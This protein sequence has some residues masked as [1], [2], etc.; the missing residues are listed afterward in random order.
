MQRRKPHT[1]IYAT[2]TLAFF[3]QLLTPSPFIHSSPPHTLCFSLS[4]STLFHC[5]LVV[6][7]ARIKM[8]GWTRGK[9]IGKG[10]FGTVH[11]A[12][13]RATGRA[14]A[15]KSVH[16][17]G[18]AP[19]AAMACLE[20][21][22]RILRRLSSP[23]I[24]AYLGDDA[25]AS[26]RNLHMELVSGGSAAARGA[27]GLGERA[28]RCVLR[29]VAAAL[30]YLHD[31]AG[32]VH[33]DVKGRNVLVGGDGAEYGSSKLADFGAARL[34]SEPAPRGPRGTPAWMAPEVARGGAST[35]A[36][37]VWS[38]GCTAVELLT[39]K[40]PWSEMGGALEVGELLLHIGYGVKRPELPACL[41]DSCSDFLD[42]CLRRDAGE[43]WSCEQLLRHPFLSADPH[44]AGEPS[45]SP[46]PRAV[47]DWAA[48]DSDSDASSDCHPAADIEDEV[49]MA[50]AKGRIAELAS[51]RPRPDWVR[52]LEEGPTWAPDTWAPP[53]SLEMSTDA[54]LLPLVP[55]PS[56]AATVA[57]AGNGGAGGPVVSRDGVLVTGGSDG[58][59][60]RVRGRCWCD[61]RRGYHKCG[62]GFDRPPCWPPL[63]V[64]SVL[65]SCILSHLIQSM[66]LFQQADGELIL[67]FA[68]VSGS[69]FFYSAVS[70]SCFFGGFD[71]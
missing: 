48:S 11:L 45:P 7:S 29:R 52:E 42:K 19:A 2:L 4:S 34:V 63:A 60:C 70:G 33:G 8:E 51:D 27:A 44:D 9:C 12:V 53:P 62:S 57:G 1:Y 5:P 41:S 36:S 18:A 49:I 59:S 66:I 30:H 43:R 21:E 38:L 10:A 31:V 17:K 13:H 35:P 24:V 71:F 68:T 15:V 40:R 54:V 69:V 56:D 20:T 28:A 47:L 32:V 16:A 58:G 14:F 25:T 67:F 61:D 65:V 39:G 23:Y 55:S 46:S 26:T 3:L 50:S 22:I 6:S 37:D 64:A